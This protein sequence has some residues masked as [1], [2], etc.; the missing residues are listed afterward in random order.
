MIFT[1]MLAWCGN[2]PAYQNIKGNFQ[3][4]AWRNRLN[5]MQDYLNLYS[6]VADY[7]GLPEDFM[8]VT[9][10]NRMWLAMK[11]F[12]PA[13]C[14]FKHPVLGLQC[15]PVSGMGDWDI[16][17][18]PTT[19]TA[20][21]ADGT[22]Y[23]RTEKDSVLMFND[24]AFSIPFIKLLYD[25][26]FMFECDNTHR[27][28]LKAQRQP[29][30]VEIE[31]DER[32]DNG[33]I[34]T[35]REWEN[36]KTLYAYRIALYKSGELVCYVPFDSN[37]I[38]SID[39]DAWLDEWIEKLKCE[40]P[41]AT[42]EEMVEKVGAA[43]IKEIFDGLWFEKEYSDIVIDNN[44]MA[45]AVG[46]KLGNKKERELLTA[47]GFVDADTMLWLFKAQ[48]AEDKTLEEFIAQSNNATIIKVLNNFRN[49]VEI[50]SQNAYAIYSAIDNIYEVSDQLEYAYEKCVREEYANKEVV[51]RIEAIEAI[52]FK[53]VAGT[54][55]AP[56]G[57]YELCVFYRSV[58]DDYKN[59]DDVKGYF[60]KYIS[61]R[62]N[63]DAPKNVRI[64]GRRI[65]W[66]EVEGAD[67][68]SIYVNGEMR[69]TQREN[70][71]ENYGSIQKGDKIEIVATGD[72]A[73]DSEP[74]DEFTY[75]PPQLKGITATVS[76][77][78]VSWNSVANAT[79]YVY[80]IN[81][82][83]YETRD[84]SIYVSA[85]GTV[86][87]KAVDENGIYLDSEWTSVTVSGG[88]SDK[89]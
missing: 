32:I 63:L 21:G 89:K 52:S 87:I 25:L 9:G 23:K 24:Y 47:L 8:Q 49:Q 42:K 10:K 68:Y 34:F 78:N 64:E 41:D 29:L 26:D 11:F 79:K 43:A 38:I 86:K 13:V 6:N 57:A 22:Q 19:W 61:V 73:Y 15:L 58:L 33:Y 60:T 18:M 14:F 55:L 85:S 44:G 39:M 27:Q 31:E 83:Q 1:N 37:D 69:F 50:T 77:R 17:G 28:N 4:I 88:S 2:L 71:Y 36:Y 59:S 67:G 51:D 80:T 7:E 74:S 40:I 62:R 75:I 16:A 46:D 12:A 20:F 81:G 53:F 82:V 35:E 3:T 84:T 70:Y 48:T 72:Y 5:K 54:N 65:L 56:A 30:I 76:G 66:D 45:E